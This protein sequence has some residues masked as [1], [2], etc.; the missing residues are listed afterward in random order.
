MVPRFSEDIIRRLKRF[1]EDIVQKLPTD[2]FFV[3]PNDLASLIDQNSKN[4]I[5]VQRYEPP[6]KK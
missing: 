6:K 3:T 4:T 1:L 2:N 5:S